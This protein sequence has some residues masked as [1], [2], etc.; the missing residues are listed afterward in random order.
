MTS[1]MDLKLYQELLTRVNEDIATLIESMEA[2]YLVAEESVIERT[3]HFWGIAGVEKSAYLLMPRLAKLA[4]YDL[5]QAPEGQRYG[6]MRKAFEELIALLRPLMVTDETL[7]AEEQTT[8]TT[9]AW[10]FDEDDERR[11]KGLGQTH[12]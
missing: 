11:R 4:L 2:G 12:D 6:V 5:P 3:Q 9:P 10:I 8:N 7:D 1:D